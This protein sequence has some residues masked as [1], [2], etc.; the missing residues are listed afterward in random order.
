M[1]DR[2]WYFSTD[3]L[4]TRHYGWMALPSV[5]LNATQPNQEFERAIRDKGD[6]NCL[7]FDLRPTYHVLRRKLFW[8]HPSPYIER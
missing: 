5:I 6:H 2:T 1:Q 4:D 7:R 3:V 8:C